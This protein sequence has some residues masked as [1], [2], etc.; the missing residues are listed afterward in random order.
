MSYQVKLTAARLK[1]S[2]A[3]WFRLAN[4]ARI[5]VNFS[6][7]DYT[8]WCNILRQNLW[9]LCPKLVVKSTLFVHFWVL[10]A[11]ILTFGQND[12]F[13]LYSKSKC[14]IIIWHNILR[15]QLWLKIL[16]I[17]DHWIWSET[18]FLYT[19]DQGIFAQNFWSEIH[20][21]YTSDHD[22]SDLLVRNAVVRNA[23]G[24]KVGNHMK[25]NWIIGWSGI[26]TTST[27]LDTAPSATSYCSNK[28]CIRYNMKV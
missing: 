20:F 7:Y 8:I 3:Q 1:K 23:V 28:I 21:L 24:R 12:S 11:T 2:T 4:L 18:Q 14:H 27:A 9:S 25:L 5:F 10:F 13:P 26:G 16:V 6:W 22:C 15:L 17:S 19:S